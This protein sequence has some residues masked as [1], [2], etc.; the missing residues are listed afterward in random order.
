MTRLL[1]GHGRLKGT[2]ERYAKRFSLLEVTFADGHAPK[3]ATLRKWRKS[4]PPSFA[5]SVVLPPSVCS[6][7]EGADDE[8]ARALEAATALEARCLVVPT[9]PEVRP[10]QANRERLLGLFSRLPRTGVLLAWEPSGLWE[11]ED[12]HFTARGIG[13]LA[14]V[15]ASQ[16]DPP[17]GPIVY[18][19]LRDI[20]GTGL[21]ARA[22]D[23][24][25]RRL[26]GRREAFVVVD[27]DRGGLAVQRALGE[28]LKREPAGSSSFIVRPT[29]GRL[30]AEDEEQ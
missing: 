24:V 8:L 22:L 29:S 4:V 12:V 23:R 21:S 1:V 30:R 27:G 16:V 26:S 14:V 3:T 9:S 5:F 17:P 18:T 11:P 7:S 19:R 6:F 25:A 15:D 20:A 13:A 10:T 28:V 2:L